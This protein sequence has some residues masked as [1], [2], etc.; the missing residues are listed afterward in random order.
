MQGEA[1]FNVLFECR[2]GERERESSF[3]FITN[4]LVGLEKENILHRV[5]S[6]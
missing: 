6:L 4:N 3:N 1:A 2:E 5:K